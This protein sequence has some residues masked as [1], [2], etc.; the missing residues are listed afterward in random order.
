MR[1]KLSYPQEEGYVMRWR[2]DKDTRISD[3]LERGW[4]HVQKDDL[5]TPGDT[6]AANEG[7]QSL[8]TVVSKVV[9]AE[10]DGRPIT[11]Y[12]MKTKKEYYDEDR[13][14]KDEYLD[15][16]ENQIREGGAVGGREV[17]RK[18]VPRS[19]GTKIERG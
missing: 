2:N 5:I 17:E 16:L 11:A 8:G 13:R 10:D 12:L 9:G 18:Y 15:S 1:R 19:G 6:D 7:G 4:D 14:L 3:L